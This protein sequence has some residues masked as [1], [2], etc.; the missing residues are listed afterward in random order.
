MARE[1]WYLLGEPGLDKEDVYP[2]EA[3]RTTIRIYGGCTLSCEQSPEL[4]HLKSS[5]E[6]TAALLEVIRSRKSWGW[7]LDLMAG[8]VTMEEA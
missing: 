5:K 7:W 1:R 3:T 4:H 8:K 6:E 2:I